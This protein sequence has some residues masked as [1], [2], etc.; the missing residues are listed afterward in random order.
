MCT[1]RCRLVSCGNI[2]LI[3]SCWARTPLVAKD[4]AMQKAKKPINALAE[5]LVQNEQA[6]EMVDECVSDLSEVNASVKGE[7]QTPDVR[8]A[9]KIVLQK[10]EVVEDKVRAVSEQLSVTND[11]LSTE[12]R[13]RELLERQFAAV[14]EQESNSRHA[15]FHDVLT[16]LPNRALFDDRLQHELAHAKRYGWSMAIMFIDLNDFKQVNDRYGHK[17]G[18]AVLQIVADRLAESSRADDTISRYGGDEFLVLLNKITGEADVAALA[19][20]FLEVLQAACE[21]AVP[22]LKVSLAIKASI[23]ISTFP[24]DGEDPELLIRKADAAMYQAKR[25]Q[26][27]YALSSD[28]RILR[29]RETGYPRSKQTT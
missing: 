10:S 20:T 9:L 16:G 25:A 17:M 3:G 2:F 11:A 15:A 5:A 6:K 13:N 21:I 14:V 7:L 8:P 18:D 26:S 4:V 19:Q 24:K 29:Q 22:D 23:G 28:A 12:V 27:G 1:I